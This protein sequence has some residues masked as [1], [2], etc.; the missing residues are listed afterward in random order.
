M[1]SLPFAVGQVVARGCGRQAASRAATERLR[2]FRSGHPGFRGRG[3]RKCRPPRLVDLFLRSTSRY[4]RAPFATLCALP[5]GIPTHRSTLRTV[6]TKYNKH[7]STRRKTQPID[8][9]YYFTFALR[10]TAHYSRPYRPHLVRLRY[11]ISKFQLD[12][13]SG[14]AHVLPRCQSTSTEGR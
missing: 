4:K 13:C 2:E 7:M 5:L 3:L 12:V 11:S 6:S 9:K 14:C 10:R 8:S 1:A